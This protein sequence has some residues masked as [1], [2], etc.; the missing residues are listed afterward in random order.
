MYNAYWL[1][2]KNCEFGEGGIIPDFKLKVIRDEGSDNDATLQ[3]Y[4]R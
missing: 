3:D 2:L 1:A 4:C